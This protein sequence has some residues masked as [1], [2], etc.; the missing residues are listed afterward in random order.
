MTFD[1]ETMKKIKDVIND[2]C[3][4]HCDQEFMDS[5]KCG[6]CP[7]YKFWEKVC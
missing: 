6:L 7:L 2:V 3:Y 4:E 1:G 5:S